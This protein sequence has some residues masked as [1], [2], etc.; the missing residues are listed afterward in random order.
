MQVA[1][2]GRFEVVEQHEN[3]CVQTAGPGHLDPEAFAALTEAAEGLPG[4]AEAPQDLRF[5]VVTVARAV[6]LQAIEQVMDT[7]AADTDGAEWW[8]G[9]ADHA[10]SAA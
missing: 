4:L 5:V 1:D 7:W 8:F 9:N 3:P 6:A 10:D 2:D